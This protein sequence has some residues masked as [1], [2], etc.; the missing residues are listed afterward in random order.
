MQSI[1]QPSSMAPAPS[2]PQREVSS[3]SD[4][5]KMI[6][7]SFGAAIFCFLL[8]FL[9]LK[10]GGQRIVA[11]TGLDMV[12]G[13]DL[14]GG[15]MFEESDAKSDVPPNIWAILALGASIA[16][17]YV[18]IQRKETSLTTGRLAGVAGVASLI[19]MQVRVRGDLSSQDISGE[20]VTLN[21]LLGYWLCFLALAAAALLCHLIL[22]EQTTSVR[23]NTTLTENLQDQDVLKPD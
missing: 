12:V 17:L 10:C 15:G 23:G 7:I 13:K 14:P 16:G 20:A 6:P 19:I 3:I 8:P 1:D 2:A 5:R 22:Q 11:Y 4:K 9:D 21:F 18:F